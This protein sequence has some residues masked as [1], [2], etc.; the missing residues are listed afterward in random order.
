MELVWFKGRPADRCALDLSSTFRDVLQVATSWKHRGSAW[1][2]FQIEA[3][4]PLTAQGC[5]SS[6]RSQISDAFLVVLF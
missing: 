6:G 2:S 4:Q 3:V 5:H 1:E